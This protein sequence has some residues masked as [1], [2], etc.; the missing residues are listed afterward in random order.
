MEKSE[1]EYNYGNVMG[2]RFYGAA[3]GIALG[4]GELAY[5]WLNYVL[6]TPQTTASTVVGLAGIP[7]MYLAFGPLVEKGADAGEIIY[8]WGAGA[9]RSI[10]K[11]KKR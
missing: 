10:K 4:E 5:L 2:A 6:N 9:L 3:A 7:L 11:Y 8:R 1:G